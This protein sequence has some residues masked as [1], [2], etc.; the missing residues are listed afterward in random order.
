MPRITRG[1]DGFTLIELLVVIAIIG[2]LMGLLLPAV[3]SAREAARRMQCT[4]NLRQL[5]LGLINYESANGAFP[6]KSIQTGVGTNIPTTAY[7]WG[8]SARLLPFLEQGAMFDGINFNFK[9]LDPSD[10]TIGAMSINIF[11]CP[12]EPNPEPIL[13][14]GYYYGVNNYAWCVGDWYVYGGMDGPTTRSAFA[15]NRSRRVAEILDGTSQTIFASEVKTYQPQLRHCFGDGS[16]GTFPNLSNPNANPDQASSL[17]FLTSDSTFGHCTMIAEGHTRWVKGDSYHGG[18]TTALTPNTK[19][20]GSQNLDLDLTSIDED[21]G[22]P[23]YAA[24]TARS[25]HPGGV[26]SLFGDGSVRFVKSSISP[27]TWRAL[28]TIRGNEVVSS[29]AY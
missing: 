1:R 4:N 25:Y 15:T 24:I 6:P 8:T 28:G 9:Y 23:T 10:A 26:N 22:G 13:F 18:F 20:V 3:Q 29:D 5:G 21:D 11:L 16:G 17:A 2:V 27:A 12:S 14:R 19:V 7:D